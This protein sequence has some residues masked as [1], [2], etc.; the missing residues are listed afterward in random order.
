MKNIIRKIDEMN[1]TYINVKCVG[2]RVYT[3]S[4]LDLEISLEITGEPCTVD[5]SG[6]ILRSRVMATFNGHYTFNRYYI[7]FSLRDVK[8]LE[9]VLVVV[10]DA[11]EFNEKKLYVKLSSTGEGSA[12]YEGLGKKL[13][14][15]AVKGNVYTTRRKNYII[16]GVIESLLDF[17]SDS[18]ENG[19]CSD[20]QENGVM[21]IGK[22]IEVPTIIVDSSV[23]F[24][25]GEG[26]YVKY[27]FDS[28]NHQAVYTENNRGYVLKH[29]ITYFLVVED[30]HALTSR[31]FCIIKG[32]EVFDE[33]VSIINKRLL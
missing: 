26:T 28:D 2:G 22:W 12:W 20:S 30:S 31:D 24:D 25:T 19:V 1:G 10:I 11:I 23:L 8:V 29:N 18:Q 13:R 32:S 15:E 7:E 6:E 21:S 33:N 16:E 5:I 3:F 14:S 4:F 27:G 17:C 9:R